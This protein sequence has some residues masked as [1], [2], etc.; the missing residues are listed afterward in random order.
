M[1][2]I[3]QNELERT[4]QVVDWLKEI[5]ADPE[6]WHRWYSDSEAKLLAEYTLELLT[7]EVKHE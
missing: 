1:G 2:V 4:A 3:P 6:N 7:L 5:I